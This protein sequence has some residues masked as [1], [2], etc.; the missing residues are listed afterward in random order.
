MT[1]TVSCNKLQTVKTIPA[2]MNLVFFDE[3]V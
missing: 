2:N 1:E 3:F